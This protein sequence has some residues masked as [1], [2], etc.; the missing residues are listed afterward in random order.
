MIN[1]GI[2]SASRISERFIQAVQHTES[3]CIYAVASRDIGRARI[4]QKKYGIDKAYGSYG[5]MFSDKSV[6]AVYVSNV[7]SL[8]FNA[9]ISA[10][11][12]GKHVVCEKPLC[13]SAKEA[14]LMI[15]AAKDHNI[16]LM[17]AMWTRF[18]PLYKT[19]REK[20]SQG[21]IGEIMQVRADFSF[22]AERNEQWRLLNAKL[23]GGA[24]YDIGI[25]SLMFILDFMGIGVRS[26]KALGFMGNTGVDEES[27]VLL[28]YGEG[29]LGSMYNSFISRRPR[30]GVVIG[31]EGEIY[32]PDFYSA[33]NA[34]IR[35]SKSGNH[36]KV[37]ERTFENKF[38]YEVEAA[39]ECME[40]GL[41]QS[42]LVPWEHSLT[43]AK[44]IEEALCQIKKDKGDIY[45]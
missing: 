23:G 22:I 32:I 34:E 1:W 44:I 10:I 29:R 13:V 27:G 37:E 3:S 11:E 40:K 38:I 20:I 5:E 17:E 8:H 45:V 30:M 31:T 43:A 19:L 18:L 9:V 4:L 26:L 33:E 2:V 36:E 21:V 28:D 7:N 42:G 24:L 35:F 12:A 15:K 6:D 41:L 14:E 16:F 39:C 25:Y